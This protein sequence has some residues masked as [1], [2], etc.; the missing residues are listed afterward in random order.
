MTRYDLTPLLRSTI[1]FDRMAR[2]MESAMHG[3]G[4]VG[5]A[6]YPPYNIE[7]LGDDDYQIT[8][9]VAGFRAEDLD[10]TIHDNTL[11]IRG[12]MQD[13]DKP[14]SGAEERF[15][16][17]GIA[18]RSF[19]Q[20]FQ[21][22]DHVAVKGADLQNGLLAVTLKREVPERLKPR[23]IPIGTSAGGAARLP[24][25]KTAAKKAA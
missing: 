25:L 6:T 14:E 20:H 23:S 12:N 9:A 7:K 15:L 17:R 1:G 21:L 2:L 22:A 11:I 24:G 8:M 16:H 18:T 5:A 10:V 13:K 19:E 3:S 4:S